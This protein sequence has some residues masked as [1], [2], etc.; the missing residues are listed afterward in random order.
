M[1]GIIEQG[2]LSMC[3]DIV[4]NLKADFVC[5]IF[6]ARPLPPGRPTNFFVGRSWQILRNSTP[7]K[8]FILL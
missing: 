6:E 5:Q 2:W 8:I 7:P 1:E 4:N 3:L